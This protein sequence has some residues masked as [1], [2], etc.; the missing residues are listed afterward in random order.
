MRDGQCASER[1][2]LLQAIASDFERLSLLIESATPAL[3]ADSLSLNGAN[4]AASKGA[5]LAR[6]AIQN[7]R[8]GPG[9]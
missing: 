1:D 2:D 4:T 3:A 6:Q 8:S 9:V 5:A 7:P